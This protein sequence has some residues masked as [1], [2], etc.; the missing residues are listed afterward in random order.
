MGK[1]SK[2]FFI[3]K[4]NNSDS[5]KIA[6]INI[7][8]NF[9]LQGVA[10]I[11]TPIFT[12]LLGSEQFGIFSLFHSWVLIITCLMGLGINSSIG[13]GLYNF[14][15]KYI[16]F[17]NSI[18]LFSTIICIIELFLIFIFGKIISGIVGI[19]Y[20]LIIAIGITA[21]TQYIINF[22][23]FSYIYEK[24]AWSNFFLSISTAFL[25]VI[26]SLIFIKY[27][28][29]NLKYIGRINGILITNI[30]ISI[31][32]W[33]TFFAKKPIF[34]KKEY[35]KFGLM[36]GF[37]IV[38]HSLSQQILGQSDRVMMQ[39]FSIS[40]AE[41]G[42]YSLFYTLC[43]VMTTISSSLN[44]A[45]CP[46]YYD[47]VDN[48]RWIEINKKSKNYIELF[49]VLTIGFILLSREVSY[50]I[51][52]NSYWSGINIIPILALAVYFTFMYQF[53]VNFEF[54]HKKTKIIALGTVFSGLLN[55]LLNYLLIPKYGMYGAAIA[56]LLSYIAL[57]IAHS[58]IVYSM[59][60]FEYKMKFK[61]FLPGIL[62]VLCAITLFYLLRNL[63]IVR[64]FIGALIGLFELYRIYKRKSIF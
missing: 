64:W 63:W 57:F 40:N 60:E 12:R 33:V 9:I 5:N 45:W 1:K 7:Y 50:I 35:L 29:N 24:K 26:I 36:V 30:C 54:F 8:S 14:K 48:N 59:K 6:L 56:T 52:D 27:L 3:K 58:I 61:L 62:S 10:F 23:Q 37:P 55:I 44:N 21:F 25:G 13:T 2:K 43:S 38:F 46:F 51:G 39:M 22:A 49:S 19:S 53:P 47:D 41:I 17:R 42:I 32:I 16:E 34:I 20:Y 28:P 4:S 31:I 15:N 11:T 18:L